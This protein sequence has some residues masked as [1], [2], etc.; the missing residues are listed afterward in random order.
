MAGLG[1]DTV[2]MNRAEVSLAGGASVYGHQSGQFFFGAVRTKVA[3]VGARY[4]TRRTFGDFHDLS[5]VAAMESLANDPLGTKDSGF[6]MATAQDALSLT[7]PFL[8]DDRTVGMNLIRSERTGLSNTIL[9]ISYAQPLPSRRASVRANAF[10]DI[11]GD[12]GYGVSV[13]LS[14]S[15]GGSRFASINVG[16]VRQG[17]METVASLSRFADRKPGSYGYRANLSQQN[18]AVDATYQTSFGRADLGLRDSGQGTNA[19]A[20]FDGALVLAGGGLFAS[21]RI[22]DGFAV[23]DVGVADVPV[24]LNNREVTRT[25]RFGKALVPGLLSYR[26]N[27]IS[28]NPLE[29]SIESNLV[30]SAMDVV[31]ARRSGV[32]VDFGG[33]P[34]AA[35]LVVLRD[36]AGEFL[37]PGADVSLQGT[38]SSFVVGYD[39][40]V[41]IDGLEA[42]NRISVRTKEKTCSAEF[43]Y[44][45]QPGGQVYID[46]IECK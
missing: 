34:N 24:S 17:R 41:W 12:G 29:L 32:A 37:S 45:A 13:G 44:A 5:S 38:Q 10:K 33:R 19:R 2:L 18:R 16:R 23:V 25:G 1:L 15:L 28:I 35:A 14:M 42:Q 22:S 36:T 20:T 4:S 46:G 8:V 6:A 26:T 39:G 31:P 27:K 30:A 21:N 43:T 9:S 7:F 40:E 11:A 3:G